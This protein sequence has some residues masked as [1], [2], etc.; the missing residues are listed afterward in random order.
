MSE[1]HSHA[2]FV[3]T[4]PTGVVTQKTLAYPVIVLLSVLKVIGERELRTK[5]KKT[6]LPH[7]AAR[8]ALK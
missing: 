6:D 8:A 3:L 1:T 5:Q 7:T 2:N 4:P